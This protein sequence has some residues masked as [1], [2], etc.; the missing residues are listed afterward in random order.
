MWFAVMMVVYSGKYSMF[1]D[2]GGY[3]DYDVCHEAAGQSAELFSPY[4]DVVIFSCSK[5]PIAGA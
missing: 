5:L 4:F 1:I 2:S 3:C